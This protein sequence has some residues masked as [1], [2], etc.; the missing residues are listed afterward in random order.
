MRTIVAALVA[1]CFAVPA[2]AQE[3]VA[4]EGK[5]EVRL[6]MKPC[7]VPAVLK[8]IPPEYHEQFYNASALV[9][10]KKYLACWRKNGQIVQLVYE[11]GDQGLMPVQ[12]FS[13]GT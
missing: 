5:D 8:I 13:R 7:S 12:M 1:A 4:T 9:A 2:F 11:D 3:M 6:T 10:G